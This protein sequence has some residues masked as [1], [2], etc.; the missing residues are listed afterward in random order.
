MGVGEQQPSPC[1]A[2]ALER[3]SEAVVCLEP[4]RVED[5]RAVMT[6]SERTTQR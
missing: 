1:G 2:Q 5:I 6:G 3:P 4:A